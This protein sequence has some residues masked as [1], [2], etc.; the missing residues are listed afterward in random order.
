[1]AGFIVLDWASEFPG[2]RK[3]LESFVKD[4][5]LKYQEDI[6][7]GFENAPTTLQRLFSGQTRGKQLLKL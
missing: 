1:M 2:I 5:S 4:G 3:R 6:Q 7:H